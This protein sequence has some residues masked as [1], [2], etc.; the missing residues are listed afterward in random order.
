VRYSQLL[1]GGNKY[2]LTHGGKAKRVLS[3][4]LDSQL[5]LYVLSAGA[6]GVGFMA[7][8]AVA[9]IVYTQVHHVIPVSPDF[10]YIDLNGDGVPDVA[11]LHYTYGLSYSQNSVINVDAHKNAVVGI[12]KRYAEPLEEGAV[13]G[14]S[15]DFKGGFRS[16]AHN[17]V[18][19]AARKNYRLGPWNDVQ[20]RYLGVSFKIG[21]ETHYGWIRMSVIDPSF[22]LEVLI[23]GY[24]RTKPCPTN[25]F[26]RDRLLTM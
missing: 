22:P 10:Q 17:R 13:I 23:T 19:D 7:Q 26:A 1:I 18:L 4:A 16:M 14:T 6:V 12:D 21:D 3:G 15:A 9:E 25:R 20:N 24:A 2:Y 11:F 5:K 8:P